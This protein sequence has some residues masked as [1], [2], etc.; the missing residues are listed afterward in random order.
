MKHAYMIMAHNQEKLLKILLKKLDCIDN[1]IF[2]H[3]DKKS[4]LDIGS[5]SAYV[6]YSRIYFAE[7]VSVTWGGY[8][9]IAA[10][11]SLMK[12]ARQ[13]GLYDFYHFMTGV[14]LPLKPIEEINNFYEQNIGK[15]FIN[16]SDKQECIRQYNLRIKYAHLFRDKCGRSKNFYTILNKAGIVLQKAINRTCTFGVD[17]FYCGSA[18]WDI[19]QELVDY[20]LDHE[21]FICDTFKYSSCCDEAFVQSLVWNN[22]YFRHRLYVEK[23]GNGRLGNMRWIDMDRGVDAG[24]YVIKGSDINEILSS[25]L[26]FARKFDYDKYPE[27]VNMILDYGI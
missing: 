6:K 23:L 18:Y 13:V 19:S 15:E 2:L 27:A 16:F 7:S 12:K 10:E 1:D 9:Q 14:D 17:D 26:L 5:L 24:A 3:I 4:R 20:I 25:G 11:L 8:S 22:E 21:S